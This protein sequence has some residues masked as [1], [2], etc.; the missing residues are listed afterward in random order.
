[1]AKRANIAK[2]QRDKLVD[3]ISTIQLGNRTAAAWNTLRSLAPHTSGTSDI[4]VPMID[5]NQLMRKVR[6]KVWD[7]FATMEDEF[8]YLAKMA[9]DDRSRFDQFLADS[10]TY[11]EGLRIQYLVKQRLQ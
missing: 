5:Q 6:K 2:R 1:V 4:G 3:I 9:R 11:E 7:S 8:H 10:F